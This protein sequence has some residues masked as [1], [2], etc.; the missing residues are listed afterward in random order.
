M[1][2]DLYQHKDILEIFPD[3]SSRSLVSWTEKELLKPD[4]GD[5]RGRGTVRKY[6]FDNIIQAGI[7]REL[8][9]LGL[10]FREIRGFYS[11]HW[12]AEMKNLNYNCVFI[13]QRQMFINIGGGKLDPDQKVNA[14]EL[15]HSFHVRVFGMEEFKKYGMRTIFEMSAEDRATGK[16]VPVGP[17]PELSSILILNIARIYRYVIN[18]LDPKRQLERKA[19]VKRINEALSK[20][21]KRNE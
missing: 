12:K 20:S 16:L 9:A 15:Y 6:S 4:Y 17:M 1:K 5:A 2:N 3:L 18:E 21:L 10:T 13:W 8:M 19:L 11:D 14:K 7:I